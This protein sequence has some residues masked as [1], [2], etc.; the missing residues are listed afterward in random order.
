MAK[1]QCSMQPSG[2]RP[3]Q[4]AF[5]KM[6]LQGQH[7]EWSA[8]VA[9]GALGWGLACRDPPCCRMQPASKQLLNPKA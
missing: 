2:R 3:S 9:W 4:S 6:R 8:N 1:L 7:K 5:R